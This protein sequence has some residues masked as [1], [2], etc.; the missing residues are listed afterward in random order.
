MMKFPQNFLWGSATSAYQVEGNNTNSDW[1]R[2][3]KD[4]GRENSGSACRHYELYNLDFDLAK[5]L[6]HNAHRLSIEWSR[7]EPEEGKFNDEE[8]KHYL[9]VILS[10]RSRNIEP[11]VTLLHFTNPLWFSKSGGWENRKSITR[12]LRYC[13]FVVRS[14]GKHVHYWVTINEPTVYIFHAYIAGIWPPQ[15]KSFLKANAVE[16][17]LIFAH[18]AAYRLIHKIYKELHLPGPSIS[19]AQYTQAFAPCTANLKNRFAA[20]L[21]DKWYNFGF[22]DRI[23]RHKTIDFIGLNYYSRQL[24]ELRKWGIGNLAMDVCKNNHHPVKKNSLGWDIY[25]EGLYGVL[26]KLKRYCLPVIITENGICTPDDNL[27]WEYIYEHLK[28]IHLAMEKGVD[29]RG[30]LY[31]SLMDNF[32]W[33]KGFSPRFGLVDIDYNT[34]KRTVRESAIKFSQ[35]CKTGILEE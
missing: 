4:T 27:R 22:L 15:V 35:V 25:P 26:L 6:N 23:M 24:V 14:L 34:F 3:E 12:F 18:I 31:W 17:N 13:E 11:I 30:Y 33:D 19:I 8:L 29:V 21:R 20:Y 9:D 2:W 28:N 10:L 32:E 5:S 16:G 7:I 1:W